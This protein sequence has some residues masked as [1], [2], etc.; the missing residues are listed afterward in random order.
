M[1]LIGLRRYLRNRLYAIEPVFSYLPG[2]QGR[3]RVDENLRPEVFNRIPELRDIVRRGG[4]D[5]NALVDEIRGLYGAEWASNISGVVEARL[6]GFTGKYVHATQMIQ[7]DRSVVRA[8]DRLATTGRQ[9]VEPM[10]ALSILLHEAF[11]GLSGERA[12]RDLRSPGPWFD[13]AGLTPRQRNVQSYWPEEAL[14]DGICEWLTLSL[15]AGVNNCGGGWKSLPRAY[16]R[17]QP[18]QEEVRMLD[19]A[20][21]DDADA[22]GFV[23]ALFRAPTSFRRFAMLSERIWGKFGQHVAPIPPL[24]GI[25]MERPWV[26]R[27]RRA[28]W[29]LASPHAWHPDLHP[30]L[31]WLEQLGHVPSPLRFFRLG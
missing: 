9:L 21:G 14:E 7:L 1:Q 31:S 27:S 25:R 20:C 15:L 26:R 23:L 11:H 8:L 28:A 16:L 19:A 3:L 29:T 24:R 5:W 30:G 17:P 6:G 10:L 12:H 18:Y 4:R 22:E 13:T 2:V